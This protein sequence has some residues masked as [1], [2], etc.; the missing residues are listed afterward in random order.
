MRHIGK[1]PKGWRMAKLVDVAKIVM[2]Q[3]PPGVT[4][5][6]WDGEPCCE[7]GLPFIQGNAEFGNDHPKPKKWCEKPL[8]VSENG[9]TLISVRAPVGETNRAN[10]RIAI[11][12]GLA[13]IRFT[14]ANPD[15]GWHMVNHAKL[16]FLRVAQGSTFHAIGGNDVRGLVVVLPPLLQ[17]RAI[18]AVLDAIDEA[19]ERT[20]AVI[21]A[22]ERLRDALLHELL[23]R[24]VSG[25]HM[26]WREV[27]GLGTVPADWQIVRLEDVAEIQTGRAVNRKAA[28]SGR[29]EVPY[30]SAVNV[31]D[32]YLEFGV[33]KTMRV[34]DSELERYRLWDG[35]VLFTE[36]GDADKLGRGTVWRG[37]INP[38]LHQNHVFAVRPHAGKLIPD[39]LAA[40]ASSSAGKR[41]FMGAAKQ[42]T[43]LA[44]VNSTQLKRM[45]LPVPRLDEQERI[46]EILASTQQANSALSADCECLRNLK[47]SAADSLLTGRVR[48]SKLAGTTFDCYS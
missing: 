39:F 45:M 10:C 26:Q 34:S 1:L 9:D 33:L 42:T 4:V 38:C 11:G 5:S 2:G 7:D 18:A 6:D 14:K 30:L 48:V 32:G 37:E 36:G 25:W 41:Y 46:T 13:A 35:D 8:K 27:P 28:R 44:S 16:E 21:G 23:T 19:I 29:H 43:N 31:K 47:T 3:S 17:Q 40:Y 15:Y 22:T 24:G 12:R 20:E